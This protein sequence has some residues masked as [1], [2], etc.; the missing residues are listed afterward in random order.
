MGP[1]IRLLRGAGRVLEPLLA[2]DAEEQR[3][4]GDRLAALVKEQATAVRD[5]GEQVAAERAELQRMRELRSSDVAETRDRMADLK[6][7]VRRQGSAIARLARTSGIH[8]QLEWTEQRIIDRL[9]RIGRSGRPV[10]VGPWTGEIG[11]ELPYW[12][13]FVRWATE[14]F[15][16][17]PDRRTILSRG[18]TR[19]GYEGLPE[20][21]V[22]VFSLVGVDEFR[23]ATEDVKKQ[24]GMRLFDRRLLRRVSAQHPD[25]PTP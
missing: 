14:K 12:I 25:R 6:S 1:L 13:P 19:A 16:L 21:Y 24:R 8:A 15:G 5:L 10:I 17:A 23:A 11:F 2:P 22:D 18:R 9:T 3:R 20:R 7:G 4:R